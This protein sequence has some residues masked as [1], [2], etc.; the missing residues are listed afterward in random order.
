AIWSG[1]IS[2][3]LIN[4]PVKLYSGVSQRA[5]RFNQ[6]DPSNMARV[7]NLRVNAET[8][9]PVDTSELVKGYEVSKGQYVVVT[10]DELAAL[11]PR[12]THTIDLEEFVELDDVDPV[13][14]DGAFHVAP[15]PGAAKPYTLLVEALEESGRVA[16][17]R[18]VM[19]SKQYV[20]LMRPVDGRLML[21]MMV[22]ADEL[23]PASD[24]VEFDDLDSVELTD[25]E[26]EMAEQLIESLAGDF[27]PERYHDEYRDD[28]MGLIN[29]KASGATPALEG[30]EAPSDDVV[31]DLMA[32]L[33]K[34]VAEAR[35][36]RGRHPSVGEE[37]DSDAAGTHEADTDEA[38]SGDGGGVGVKPPAKSASKSQKAS[39]QKPTGG[40]S[41]RAKSASAKSNGSGS[42]A[43]K[44]KAPARKARKSA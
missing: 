25:R 6:L 18:F 10:D 12:A 28:L 8:G 4:I 9:E 26:R 7:R 34:S 23:N 3:G 14:F 29:A 37:A 35:E 43:A 44:K 24:I 38:D 1:A 41:A 20:A 40:S 27:E 30:P 5:V 11:Q 19:R 33:E 2:F 39:R 42:K 22:Y 17:A 31:V 21:S 15:G 13:Y 16:V 36:A 32:A